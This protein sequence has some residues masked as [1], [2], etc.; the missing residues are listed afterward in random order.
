M[1]EGARP[2]P[3]LTIV[4]PTYNR[5]SSLQECLHSVA[6]EMGSSS[7][8]VI[9]VDDASNDGSWHW[10]QTIECRSSVHVRS[11]RLSENRGPGSARNVG[12]EMAKGDYFC[13][14]DSDMILMGGAKRTI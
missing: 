2:R 4:T 9:V 7:V 12:L 11:V 6:T 10:L 1:P 8:E 3:I 14:L 13:P 5:L